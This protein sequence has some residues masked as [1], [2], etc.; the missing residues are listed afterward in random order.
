MKEFLIR[1]HRSMYSRSLLFAAVGLA[2]GMPAQGQSWPSRP[3]TVLV[4]SAPGGA[5][6]SYARVSAED[7]AS[8]LKQPVIVENKPGG[9][10]GLV[11]AD[12]AARAAPDGLTLF[13]GTAA[14]LTINP[15]S[16]KK[17]PYSPA[18]FA[19]VCKG[20]EFPLVLVANPSIGVKDVKGLAN[21]LKAHPAEASYSSYQPGTPSHF[22]G[23]QLGEKLGIPLTHIPYRGS[24]PQVTDLLGGT[25]KFG[26]TQLVTALPHIQSGK[27]VALAT[28]GDARAEPLKDI[29]TL[30]EQGLKEL[31]TSAWF[32]LLVPKA[33]PPAIVEQLIKAHKATIASPEIRAKWS[34]QS[35]YPSGVCGKEFEKQVRDEAARWA[36]V[37]KAT[38]FSATE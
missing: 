24:A 2:V 33:T 1:T 37:V 34:A 23:Y 8:Q 11:A 38:G 22:L 19:Y 4:P 10:G 17:L 18:D 6:D 32:G 27:L 30:A 28:T 13:V 25:V 7:L 35:L 15:S 5:I 31:T 16:Y 29:P 20:V 36:A 12:A 21:W 26:F 14:I 3:I 9:G